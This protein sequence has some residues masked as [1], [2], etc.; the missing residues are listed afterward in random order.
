M[1]TKLIKIIS[2]GQTGVDRAALDFA[3]KYQI[4]CGGWCPKGRI[5]ED[6]IIPDQY[7]L[8]ETLTEDPKERTRLNISNSDGTLII[9]RDRMDEGTQ[10]TLDHAREFEKAV[11][12]IQSGSDKNPEYFKNW[13]QANK[14]NT[15]NVAGPRESSEAGVYNFAY[16]ALENLF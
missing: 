2:G 16:D 8:T 15:L 11:Y 5:A 6:G 7:P 12:I 1:K 4:P 3:L 10:Y 9:Y 13:L 14:I